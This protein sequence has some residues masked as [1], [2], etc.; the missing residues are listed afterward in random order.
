MGRSVVN[1]RR[2][3]VLPAPLGPRNPKIS[4]RVHVETHAPDG[5]DIAPV[6]CERISASP[7][8]R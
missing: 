4:P 6:G 7:W 5:V 2:V 3:V 1:I 8:S